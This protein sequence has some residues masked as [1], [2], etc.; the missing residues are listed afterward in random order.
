MIT[1]SNSSFKLFVEYRPPSSF[2]AHFFT[3]FESFIEIPT[4]SHIDLLIRDFN[5]NI[6]DL[7]N[8]S[9]RYFLKLLYL[10]D[11]RQRITHP[12]HYSDHIIDLIITNASSKFVINL[13]CSIHTFQIAKLFALT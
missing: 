7:S 6:D 8:Y 3:E 12:T 2:I 4:N 1:S 13:F 11:L 10:F 5:I 9:A